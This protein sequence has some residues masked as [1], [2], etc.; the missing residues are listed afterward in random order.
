MSSRLVL[1]IGLLVGAR[2]WQKAMQSRNTGKSL[3]GAVMLMLLV[4]WSSTTS[5]TTL[6]GHV[7]GQEGEPL[8]GATVKIQELELTILTN[9]SGYFK[10]ENLPSRSVTVEAT[11]EGYFPSFPTKIDL[12]DAPINVMDIQLA[13]KFIVE[14]TVVVTGTRREEFV[15]QAPVRT[16]LLQQEIY[17][18]KASTN[19][20]EALT[21]TI[22]GVRVE[23]NCQNCG[24]TQIRLNGLEGKYTQILE[25]GLPTF[26]GVAMVYGIEQLPVEF[27]EQIEVVKGGASALYGPNAVGGVI[28]LVRRMP[29]QTRF[30]I[31]A[32]GGAQKGHPLGTLSLQGQVSRG[33]F[34]A[35]FYFRGISQSAVD[36]DGD[37]FTDNPKRVTYAGGFTLFHHFFERDARLS[38]GGTLMHEL[39]R[40]GEDNFDLPPDQT[41]IT[42]MAESNRYS[43]FLRWN[44]TISPDTYYTLATNFTHLNRDTYYGADFDPNAYGRT[45]NP[46]WNS[47]LSFGHQLG[48]HL[49][50]G[51]FQYQREGVE[52][53]ILAYNRAFDDTFTNAGVYIQDQFRATYR[54]TLVGGLRI[55]KS[56]TL[57]D[58]VF[59]PRANIKIGLNDNLSLRLGLSTGFR[60]PMIFDEDLHITQVGGEG[61]VIENSPDLKEER[62]LSFTGALDFVGLVRGLPYQFGVNVFN[63]KLDD[64]H[65]L[66]ETDVV[67]GDYRQLLRVNGKGSYVRGLELNWDLQ[68]HP[69]ANLR[70]GATFQVSRYEEP[71]PQF[72]S[73]RY[74][75]TPDRYGFAGVDLDLPRRV[76]LFTT[77]DLTGPMLVPHLAGY[78][79]ED[80]VE[81]S[82]TFVVWN[83]VVGRDFNTE[84]AQ[85]RFYFAIDNILDDYQEDL[86]RGP[87]RDSGYVYGPLFGRRARAGCTI[88]F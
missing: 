76:E 16:E 78:I 2:P 45:K 6:E 14:E 34:G 8:V 43:G 38:L 77:V 25:D 15:S 24:F 10:F 65:V 82:K 59:S 84:T 44:H 79:S 7:V 36:R 19:L 9:E 22:P 1:L 3:C 28:N 71:E 83:A 4:S 29:T 11:A 66:E 72:G 63:T 61:L 23:A 50:L 70:G 26:S 60:A 69:R 74:F 75:R 51:G 21:A 57:S 47:D 81:E 85:M 54:V 46:L 12:N 62:S 5:A 17:V 68:I 73:T 55:D 53:R 64:V 80:R 58:P 30:R 18:K 56:N 88:T 86:D 33:T 35:D 40:G 87:L 13:R 49:L 41:A 52:D 20:A 39:R 42:E 67:V 32:N 31:D 37:G 27:F 48:E